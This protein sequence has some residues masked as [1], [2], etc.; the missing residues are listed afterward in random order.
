MITRRG[1]LWR[2]ALGATFTGSPRPTEQGR[3]DLRAPSPPSIAELRSMRDQVR[4]ITVEERRARL[5][6]ARRL[7]A[8]HKLDAIL[9]TGGSSL[10]YFAGARW[11]NSERLLAIVLPVRG[12]DFCVCP[13]FEEERVREQLA[14]GPLSQT[15]IRT[16]QEDESPFERIAQ[17]LK[18]RGV[19]AGRLGIEE[20]AKFVY[21]D[22][23][24]SA[25]PALRLTSATPVT[26]GCRMIK[27][28]HEVEFMRLASQATL[29]CYEAVFRALMPGMTE[30]E[31]GGLISA[32]YSRLGFPGGASVQVGEST[33]LPHGSATPQVIREGTIIMIDDGC[34]VEGY[35]SDITR[36]FVL[37]LATDK[38]KRV[39]DIVHQAQSVALKAARPGVPLES[40]DASARTTIVNAGYGPAFKYFTHRLG[41]GIG[42]DG[43]E[44]PYL[45]RNNMFG[46]EKDIRLRPGM[47]FSDEPGIYIRGEFGIRL[48]DDMVITDTGAE[49]FTPQSPSIE[50]P[51]AK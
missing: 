45:I 33:A 38:M 20:T 31:V 11:G 47:V 6:K 13:A 44:W 4:P 7:M 10:T 40:V 1:F 15:D 37:G 27:D 29:K 51:F 18:D 46:W 28:S 48:E 49:L 35:Q 24:A 8:E 23:V 22:G 21:S 17:A 3:E 25:A 50:D 32:A 12:D 5:A 14:L 19:K 36:T 34:S 2:S 39:F 43:H 16:W 42:M 30:N 26:A 41:H 9:L